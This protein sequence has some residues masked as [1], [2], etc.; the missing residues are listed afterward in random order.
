[1][2]RPPVRLAVLRTLCA[3]GLAVLT[4]AAARADIYRCVDPAGAV[5]YGDT[6]CPSGAAMSS[7]ITDA[8][9][10]TTAECQ[11]QLER[12]R[13]S[14]EE[15]LRAERATLGEMQDRRLKAEELDLQR[16]LM[17]QHDRLEAQTQRTADG[18]GA[19]YPAYPLYSGVG[20]PGYGDGD[21][22]GQKRNCR[23]S[24]CAPR[25]DHTGLSRGK[26]FLREPMVDSIAPGPVRRFRR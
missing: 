18:G 21:W 3:A 24:V 4:I 7:N 20:Y 2:H 13:A 15:R 14:A 5:T 10:C 8:V 25:L 16:R 17:M 9:S 26:Q 23:G 22:F 19:Y 1:M 12:A 11:A 6:P